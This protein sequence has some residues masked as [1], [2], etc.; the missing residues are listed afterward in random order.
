MAA[1][2]RRETLPVHWSYG[3]CED[4]RIFFIDDQ[5]RT[6]TWLHPRTGEPVN[7]GHM[8]RSDLPRGWE[9]GFTEEGASYFINHNQRTSSFRHPVTGQISP[10]NAEYILKEQPNTQMSRQQTDQRPQSMIS[11]TSTAVTVSTVDAAPGSRISKPSGKIHSFGKREQSSKRNPNA[12][13][14]VR[15]W[16]Y[17][18]DSSGMRLW[19]R[20]WFALSEYC[21]FYYKDSREE[22]VLGSIPLPSYVISLVDPEDHISRKY[23]FKATHT[24]MRAY[25]YNKNSVLGS[26]ADQSGMRTYYFSADTQEDM[27]GWI[28]AMNQAALMQAYT[29]KREPEKAERPHLTQNNYINSYKGLT[30]AD[31]LQSRD[32]AGKPLDEKFGFEKYDEMKKDWGDEERY[33]F[34]KEPIEILPRKVNKSKMPASSVERDMFTHRRPLSHPQSTQRNGTIQPPTSAALI[35]QN[36]ADVYRRGFE[37]RTGTA[38]NNQRK[39]SMVHVEHWVKSHKGDSKSLAVA[40]TLPHRTLNQPQPY[41]ENYQT[42]PK[43]IGQPSESYPSTNHNLPSD[44]KYAQDRVSHLKMSNE[45]RKATKE[46]TVWQLYEWQQRQ[47]FKHGSPTAPLYPSHATDFD[48]GLPKSAFDVPR[49]ISVPPSPSDIPPP[50]PPK[51]LSPRRPHTPAERVTVKP[52]ETR[53]AEIILSGSPGRARGT[54]TKS[55][56]H[57][58]RRSMPPMGYMTHTVSAPSL[59]G[60][61]PEE[62]TLLLI[63]LR[64]HQSKLANVRNHT[65]TQLQLNRLS[66][67]NHQADDTYMQLKKNLEYLDLKMKSNIPLINM[68]HRMVTKVTP[69]FRPNFQVTGQEPVR[70]V[71]Q[72]VKIAESNADAK[73]SRLCERDKCLQD[74]EAKV[75][76]LKADKDQLESVLEVTHR[77]LDQYKGQPT[78]TEKIAYQQ[79]L[80]QEDLVQIRAEISKVCTELEKAWKE[81]EQTENDVNQLK[82]AILGYMKTAPSSQD[83]EQIR[84]DLWRIEDV[85][86]GL[87]VNKNNYKMI[88]ESIQNPVMNTI[89][90]KEGRSSL[91]LSPS[92]SPVLEPP[93]PVETQFQTLQQP[94][95]LP[96]FKPQSLPQFRQHPMVLEDQAPPR[97][98]LPHM[99]SPDDEPPAVPPLPKDAT[100]IRHTSVRGLKRQSDERKRDREFGLYLNGDYKA[101][102]RTYM[103]EPELLSVGNGLN[104]STTGAFGL[105]NGLQTLT[106][107]GLSSSNSGLQQSSTIASFVTLRRKNDETSSKERPKSA[108]ERLYG[109]HQRGR[110]SAEEQLERMKRHQKA[111]VRER[112]RTLSLGERHSTSSRTSSRP[113]SVDVG[114]WKREQEFDLQLLEKAV[115]GEHHNLQDGFIKQSVPVV[116]ADVEPLDYDLDLS[117]ELSKPDMVLIPER[118]IELEPE[119][120]LTNEEYEARKRKVQKI[121]NILSKLSYQ[122]VQPG[123]NYVNENSSDLDSQLQERER[124]ITMSYALAS[125]ASQRSKI[126][127]AQQQVHSSSAPSPPHSPLSN[128]FHYTFV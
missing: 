50:G 76:Q 59:H 33:G 16:L 3:V 65:F 94:V 125:E 42:L 27:N 36:G 12:P 25:M 87:S 54:L 6:T 117:K 113:L 32:S 111:L 102:L 85:M 52:L 38:K 44:Y 86:A 112:K 2:L 100:V 108:L 79:R 1:E 29:L 81:Y 56:A 39:S 34:Q 14:V 75:R 83:Q 9:E 82:E 61:T 58:D 95:S 62:L 67:S 15:G 11:E 104:R 124:I 18:Q 109:E 49:S 74:L 106:G 20:R 31:V 8:I 4:G 47:Q 23:A 53:P 116:E 92:V 97:P 73:L 98:P 48:S 41:P 114:S 35:D 55:S 88:I 103:S 90:L 77:Q 7:S 128:G 89:S 93:E 43:N 80:L 118:Y 99:Y 120:P 122:N 30:K 96:P 69:R 60:K 105:D 24:G 45:D 126:V 68:V 72:P 19:K 110:M 127:A 46:G 115:K 71:L 66:Q 101:E 119:E 107:K 78:H 91:Q 22:T 28:R 123:V 84:K 51:A 5:T 26:Q 121:K 57:V 37:P 17:K 63:R 21:L 10:E 70:R 13:V 64:R 40:Q